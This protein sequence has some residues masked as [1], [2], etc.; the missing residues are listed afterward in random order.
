MSLSSNGSFAEDCGAAAAD[1]T[2]M[3]HR[4]KALC[5]LPPAL[6]YLLLSL[7]LYSTIKHTVQSLT[8]PQY[9]CCLSAAK[10]RFALAEETDLEATTEESV[11]CV[12]SSDP[13]KSKQDEVICNNG[14]VEFSSCP[15]SFQKVLLMLHRLK[16][17]CKVP[18]IDTTLCDTAT[19][20]KNPD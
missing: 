17:P 15:S 4:W 13:E 6:C 9:L 10:K 5:G 12:S 8:T 14:K 3:R 16:Q 19:I 11:E 2:R 1:V 20:M 18:S 7:P